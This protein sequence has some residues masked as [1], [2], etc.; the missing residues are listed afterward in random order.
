MCFLSVFYGWFTAICR[1]G[2]SPKKAD[3]KYSHIERSDSHNAKFSA[4]R[5]VARLFAAHFFT[6]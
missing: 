1:L 2:K 6:G 3:T 5:F 4:K